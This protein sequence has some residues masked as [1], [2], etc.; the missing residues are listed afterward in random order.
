[1]V[2]S[3]TKR[4]RVQPVRTPLEPLRFVDEK[5]LISSLARYIF[6]QSNVAKPP[7]DP[8]TELLGGQ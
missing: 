4:Q 8:Y 6:S 5:L 1:M 3:H 7:L 2:L